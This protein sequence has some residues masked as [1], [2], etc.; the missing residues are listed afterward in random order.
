VD[1]VKVAIDLPLTQRNLL[2]GMNGPSKTEKTPSEFLLPVTKNF[3][4]KGL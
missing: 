2:N 1:Q 3:P 4:H